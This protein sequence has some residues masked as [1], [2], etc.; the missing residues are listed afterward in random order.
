[1]S[2]ITRRQM[3]RSTA[4]TGITVCATGVVRAHAGEP[5]P[6]EKLNIALIGS[7]G[8]GAA[9]LGSVRGEN[10]VALCDV[11]E[12][13]AAKTFLQYPNAPKFADFRIMLDK[14]D[15][16]IDAVVVS[17]PEQVHAPASVTAMRH[18]KHCYCEKPLTHE[19]YEAR[20]AAE[21]ATENK[22]ATQMGTQIHAG[23]NYRRVVELVQSG[24]IG[25]VGECHVWINRA[26]GGGERPT[27]TPPVPAGLDWD[28]WLGPAPYRP[29]HPCYLPRQWNFWWDFGGGNLAAMGCHYFDLP[30]WALKLRHPTSAETTGPPLHPE[31]TPRWLT[32]HYEF[33]K[34]DDLPPVTL[35]YCDGGRQPELLKELGLAD[36][37]SGVLFVG[38]KGMLIADYGRRK[39][40][41]ENKFADL[42]PPEPF[43]PNSIGHHREWIEACKTGGPT[44]CNFDYSGA[45]TETVLLGNVSYRAGQ[46]IEW[47]AK[48][49]K[50]TNCPEA[51]KYIRRE[52]RE[53][54]TL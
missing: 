21:V 50:A 9:N 29:Y 32:I 45:V 42:E 41:P 30:F 11:D 54:W 48:N 39:L 20:V 53:G 2:R 51:D 4:L 33:P 34:R 38:S 18:G 52:Y 14:M 35:F 3:L 7:G 47:D 28:L 1:M 22:L 36:W 15:R 44:T 26:E 19:I 24:A 13:R 37:R 16:E 5:T 12:R 46:R 17:T 43:I 27:D 8:R 10:I 40:L 31:T 25:D 49:M 23:S 6:N